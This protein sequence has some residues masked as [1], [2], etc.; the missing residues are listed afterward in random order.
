MAAAKVN[1][2]KTGIMLLAAGSSSRLGSPKQLLPL[3]NTTLLQHSLDVAIDSGIRP[4]V[5]ILGSGAEGIERKIVARTATVVINEGWQEGMASS[6]RCGLKVLLAQYPT[7]DALILMVCDQPFI[8]PEIL[9]NLVN[10][11][12]ES[13][14]PIIT[15]S[16]GNTFGPPTLFSKKHFEELMLLKGD[17]GARSIINRH[18]QEVEVIPFADGNLDI[19]TESDYKIMQQKSVNT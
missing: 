3:K 8:T 13:G 16:Y 11:H 17:T 18:L 15:C 1:K 7:L 12:A 10:A 5:V 4:I 14:K 9:K 6:L 2:I 19:D